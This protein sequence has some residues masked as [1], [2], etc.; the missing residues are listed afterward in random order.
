MPLTYMMVDCP[1]CG[2]H[3]DVLPKVMR[4]VASD[5]LVVILWEDTV[6][7]HTCKTVD[8]AEKTPKESS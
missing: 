7:E 4:K 2:A 3:L 8:S 6:V 5:G 1:E